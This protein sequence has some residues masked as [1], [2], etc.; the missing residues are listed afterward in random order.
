MQ[1]KPYTLHNFRKLPQIAKLSKEQQKSIEVVGSVLPF[2]TNN[3]VVEQLI[4][5]SNIPND[6]L[7]VTTFPQKKMLKP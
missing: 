3:Y 6:P 7:F 1:Y 2:K 5:W 4:D